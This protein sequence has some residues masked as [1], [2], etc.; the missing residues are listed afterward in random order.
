MYGFRIKLRLADDHDW[1]DEDSTEVALRGIQQTVL[2]A[3]VPS[4]DGRARGGRHFVVEGRHFQTASEAESQGLRVALGILWF[5]VT[6]RC[7][8]SFSYGGALPIVVISSTSLSLSAFGMASLIMSSS[9]NMIVDE[10]NRFL[11]SSARPDESTRL[12][13]ELYVAAKL[14]TSK[15]ARF[16]SMVSAL[17]PLIRPQKLNNPVIDCVIDAAIAKAKAAHSADEPLYRSFI[18]RL[19]ALRRES[20]SAA[21]RRY[22]RATLPDD[23]AVHH[24]LERAYDLRSK[25]LHDGATLDCPDADLEFVDEALRRLFAKLLGLELVA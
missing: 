21:L 8:L 20:V 11:S 2:R 22:V 15:R 13:L 25:V 3:E 1:K 7:P 10:V 16:V 5:A 4:V 14:E 6:K 9:R 12:A 17:E 24:A 23:A 19:E 18:G